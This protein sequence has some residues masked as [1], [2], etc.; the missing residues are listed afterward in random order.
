[1]DIREQGAGYLS[2]R[3]VDRGDRTVKIHRLSAERMQGVTTGQTLWLF[4]LA[5][6]EARMFSTGWRHPRNFYEM[7]MLPTDRTAWTMRMFSSGG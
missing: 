5:S 2:V 3:I 1:M 7:A 4:D 6:I